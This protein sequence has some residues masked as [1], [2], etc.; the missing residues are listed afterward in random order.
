M[1]HCVEMIP[2][3]YRG[4]RCWLCTVCG[5]L[6]ALDYVTGCLVVLWPGRGR[7]AAG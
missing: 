2:V 4:R 7:R 3:R 5:Y 6:T 1:R